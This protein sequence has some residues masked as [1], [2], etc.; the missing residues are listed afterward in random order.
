VVQ[1]VAF[2]FFGC[3]HLIALALVTCFQQD[4]C[5]ILLDVI[6]HVETSISLFQMALQ[7]VQI[8]LPQVICSQVSPFESLVV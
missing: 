4:D 7:D 1:S 2:A 6:T 3:G 8:M 5:P